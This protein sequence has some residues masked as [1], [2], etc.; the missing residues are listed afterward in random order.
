MAVAAVLQLLLALLVPVIAGKYY[1]IRRIKFC[2]NEI[3]I[4]IE[5]IITRLYITILLIE[6]QGVLPP[7]LKMR[8]YASI[9]C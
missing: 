2:R 5:T 6:H 9:F 3:T 7:Y 1:Y 4:K 8:K